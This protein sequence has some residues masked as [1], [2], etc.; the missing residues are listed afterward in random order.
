MLPFVADTG[1]IYLVVGHRSSGSCSSWRAVQLVRHS[2]PER[3][4]KFFTLSNIYLA[5]LFAAIAVDT[6]VRSI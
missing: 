1:A 4:I 6:L 3:A 5:S 2:T